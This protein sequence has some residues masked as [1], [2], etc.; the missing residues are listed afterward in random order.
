MP[1]EKSPAQIFKATF[2]VWPVQA[3]TLKLAVEE[4]VRM[5]YYSDL[6]ACVAAGLVVFGDLGRG[7]PHLTDKGW[8]ALAANR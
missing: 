6:R 3:M 7:A 5:S 2:G 8:R 4:H 1:T